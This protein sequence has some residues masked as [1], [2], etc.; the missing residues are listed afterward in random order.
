MNKLTLAVA[1]ALGVAAIST[2]HA[3]V[4][5]QGPQL[6]GFALQSITTNQP[7][8]TAVTLP[9][10]ETVVLRPHASDRLETMRRGR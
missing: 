1:A 9:S 8:V 4:N 7:I 2:A 3:G 10:G 6:T 5:L